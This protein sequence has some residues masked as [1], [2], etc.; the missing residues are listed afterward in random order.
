M[1]IAPEN[2]S[3]LYRRHANPDQAPV[4]TD[5]YTHADPRQFCGTARDEPLRCFLPSSLLIGAFPQ[6]TQ[7]ML[8]VND[9]NGLGAVLRNAPPV[10]GPRKVRRRMTVQGLHRRLTR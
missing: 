6:R 5:D 7:V 9:R 8:V 3:P 10:M 1:D 4:A 2:I